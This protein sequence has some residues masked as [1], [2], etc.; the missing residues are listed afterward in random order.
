MKKLDVLYTVNDKYI[1]ICLAS[2]IS[3]IRNSKVK[4]LVIHIIC[5]DFKKEDY[6]K[7]SRLLNSFNCEYYLYDIK[8]F[9]IEKYNIPNWRGSQIA[10]ARLFFQ[11]I[12]K[13]N[14][15]GINN[16]L[17]LDSD[18][19]VVGDLNDLER[20]KEND[21][22]AV[23]DG[24]FK[25]YV[26]KMGL[27][28]YFNSGVIL[29]NVDNWL[30]NNYQDEVVRFLEKPWAEIT[31]PDQD[32]LNCAVGEHIK[33]LPL[34]FNLSANAYL[35]NDFW[36]KLYFNNGL[37]YNNDDLLMAKDDPKILHSTGVLSIKPWTDNN[38]NP[39]NDVFMSYILEANPEFQKVELS[40]LKK[41][42]SCYPPIFKMLVLAKAFAPEKV[43]DLAR[44]LTM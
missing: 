21:I 11:E 32:A 34:N 20:Y 35:F 4:K 9:D 3:L 25:T 5:S 29:F 19:V 2:I 28:N 40:K 37:N 31:F 43:R 26:R 38:V 12:M 27:S 16:L 17:Y 42:L 24:C 13:N 33:E 41:V 8:T 15:N 30:N 18:L 6:E 39:F 10:N 14:L 22:S 44:K 36:Q 1:D 7:I 23:K